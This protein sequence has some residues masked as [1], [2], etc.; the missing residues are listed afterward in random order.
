MP[1]HT[2]SDHRVQQ[3]VRHLSEL[4]LRMGSV[5]AVAQSLSRALGEPASRIYPNRIH[6]LLTDDSTRGVNTA[7]LEL[8]ERAYHALEADGLP[9]EWAISIEAVRAAVTAETAKGTPD[10]VAVVAERLGIPAGVVRFAGPTTPPEEAPRAKPT[11]RTAPD[12]SWQDD[13]VRR[14]LTTLS[15]GSTKTGLVVPTGGG[16]TRIA[17]RIALEWLSTR[18]DTEVVLW[19]THRHHLQTQARRTLQ[20]LLR[21]SDL[22]ADEAMARF[23][24]VRFVMTTHLA[25]T[26]ADLGNSL[27]LVI[28]DEAHHAAAA[29]Y[30]PVVDLAEVPGLF[31]TA[32]PNR[33]DGLPIGIDN[34]AYTIT[35][36]ELFARGC[37]IEPVFDSPEEMP[38]IDWSSA[39]SV[40]NFADYLLERTDSDFAKPLVA[41]SLQARAE[42][43]YEA[44]LEALEERG[45]HPLT[46]E[47]IGFVHGDGNSRALSNPSDFLDE[48]TA[49][50]AGILI[51]TSQL[52]GEGFDDPSIDAAIIAFPSES[53]GHL[54]QIAG[55]AMRWAPGKT[56]AHVVQVRE[57]PL[58]YHFEQRWLYQDISDALRPQL[59][60]L[61][62][63]SAEDLTAKMQD[64]LAR[65]HVPTP[66]R[67]RVLT[68]LQSV[69]VGERLHLMLTGLPYFGATTDFQENA[70]WD[71][72]LVTPDERQ[73]F[74]RIF[75]D[76]S[77]RTED[78]D[79]SAYLGAHLRLDPTTG[80]VWRSY[81]SLIPAMEY[82]R[83]EITHVT[84]QGRSSRDYKRGHS[85]S[86]LKYLT[87]TFAPT[88]PT[89][90]EEF[91]SDAYNRDLVLA[92]YVRAPEFWELALRVE[93]PMFG[94]EAFLLDHDHAAWLTTQL[95]WLE[96]TLARADRSKVLAELATWRLSLT[97]CPLSPRVIDRIEQF[98]RPE[99][100]A[101]HQL[102]LRL[103]QSHE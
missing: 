45:N 101:Q 85:T 80:S 8:L 54:M 57:S 6:G 89:E 26:I 14:C 92:N 46:F 21:E 91:L 96:A 70:A 32:T 17:L 90:L 30:N 87:F 47:D 56:T 61:T 11:T 34:I 52:V 82:A 78:L 66:V 53:I 16:K 1:R 49:R 23:E 9:S 42:T 48:F 44:L 100:Q 41:V 94:S 51:A 93:L 4:V 71:S 62:Y 50:P 59:L 77:A 18:P 88:V 12:W 43:L 5:N 58:Q 29:S 55:R 102:N 2:M 35:Y 65:H 28:I 67:T 99:R 98:L 68:E 84:Y 37:V 97:T 33:L 15:D 38:E 81:A 79:Q 60:D 103:G 27:S 31:L 25:S 13:A 39:E 63:S 83:R 75:N 74:V 95:T 20:A 40:C 22:P 64:Q 19:V 72:I 10:A 73:R 3:M 7:T 24:R 36:Q 69:A 86:W 76:V